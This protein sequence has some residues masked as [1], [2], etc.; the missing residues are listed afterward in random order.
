M[1]KMDTTE[2][3][4]EDKA[5]SVQ[6]ESKPEVPFKKPTLLIGKI[7][8]LPRKIQAATPGNENSQK[9]PDASIEKDPVEPI[10]VEVNSSSISDEN[11]SEGI[12]EKLTE[13]ISKC[14]LSL[15]V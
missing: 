15:I 12:E 1:N 3:V 14:K 7:G 4:K 11:K 13:S 5:G 6:A 10:E 8:R 2:E 9:I